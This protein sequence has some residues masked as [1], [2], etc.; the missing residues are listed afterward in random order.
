MSI[1]TTTTTRHLSQQQLEALLINA[2]GFVDGNGAMFHCHQYS[3]NTETNIATLQSIQDEAIDVVLNDDATL[4]ESTLV[5]YV[6]GGDLEQLTV[7]VPLA[8]AQVDDMLSVE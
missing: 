2:Y 6:D 7:L 8:L 3:F 5:V 4:D 1:S